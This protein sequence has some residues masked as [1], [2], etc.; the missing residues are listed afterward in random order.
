MRWLTVIGLALDLAGAFVVAWPLLIS[1][2][3]EIAATAA[4]RLGSNPLVAL[5]RRRERDLLRSGLV[6]IAV[7]FSFQLVAFVW[8]SFTPSERVLAA[9]LAGAVVV[10][11][12][13]AVLL[14]TRQERLATW[15][16]RGAEAI[17]DQ[18]D[19][20]GVADRAS[21]NAFLDAAR[22]QGY[23]F[24]GDVPARIDGG[25]WVAD[26]SCTSGMAAWP[27]NERVACIDCGRE[28]RATFPPDWPSIQE[29]LLKVDRPS[30][31]TWSP[32]SC[33]T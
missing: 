25:R 30:N 3:S 7:G 5:G 26:C 8:G 6:L 4:T 21:V 17:L 32:N 16:A 1:S 22:P 27:E 23:T 10:A 13:V 31:R 24:A 19:I 11:C 18:R 9:C 29:G 15:T 14:R 28:Y 12:V 20:Y 33:G 2:S